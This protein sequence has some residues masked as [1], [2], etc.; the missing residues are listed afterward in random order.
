MLLGGG[1]V[2]RCGDGGGTASVT[3]TVGNV[4]PRASRSAAAAFFARMDVRIAAARI[5]G[6][7][8]LLRWQLREQMLDGATR[9]GGRATRSIIVAMEDD[10]DG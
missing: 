4:V 1:R 9:G 3:A 6:A 8:M 10:G 2:A 5:A 7:A